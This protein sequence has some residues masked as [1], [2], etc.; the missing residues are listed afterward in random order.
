MNTV[1]VGDSR[2]DM[3]G[4]KDNDILFVGVNYGFGFS[5]VKGYANTS[6]DIKQTIMKKFED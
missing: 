6:Y 3:V 4:A 1:F 5:N 2:N